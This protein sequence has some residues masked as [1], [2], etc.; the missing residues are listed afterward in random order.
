[1]GAAD[2]SV[3]MIVAATGGERAKSATPVSLRLPLLCLSAGIRLC[4]RMTILLAA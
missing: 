3:K 2:P 4:A 1:M